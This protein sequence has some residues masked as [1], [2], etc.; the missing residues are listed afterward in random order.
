MLPQMSLMAMD[1]QHIEDRL[2]SI[3][4]RRF[5]RSLGTVMPHS[6]LTLAHGKKARLSITGKGSAMSQDQARANSAA[7]GRSGRGSILLGSAGLAGI[8]NNISSEDVIGS[9]ELS[10]SNLFAAPNTSSAFSNPSQRHPSES[11][12]V[13]TASSAAARLG[14]VSKVSLA[15]MRCSSDN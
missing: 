12:S 7:T 10:S 8:F 13:A 6:L 2:P 11:V 14:L 4:A 15:T 3:H 1:A 9:A 5:S